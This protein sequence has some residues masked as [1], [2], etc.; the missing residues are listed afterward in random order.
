MLHSIVSIAHIAVSLI[1][2]HRVFVQEEVFRVI[3][4]AF[5]AMSLSFFQYNSRGLVNL[6]NQLISQ[7]FFGKAVVNSRVDDLPSPGVM[8][9]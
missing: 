8:R 3:T 7:A 6:V 5:K 2:G 9:V 1:T 4:E